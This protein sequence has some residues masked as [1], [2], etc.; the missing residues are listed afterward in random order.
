[1]EGCGYIQ[2]LFRKSNIFSFILGAIIFGSI[3]VVSAYTLY[4]NDIE[5]TPKDTTWKKEDGSDITN[6]KEAID[7]LY[8]SK[9][10]IFG[11]AIYNVSNGDQLVNR[12]A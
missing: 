11:E 1:M 6:V 7:E 2:K 8:N 9:K 4:A 5:Y 3:G 10:S 12:T